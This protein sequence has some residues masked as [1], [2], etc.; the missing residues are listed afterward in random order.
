MKVKEC[1]LNNQNIKEIN[2]L[3]SKTAILKYSGYV[4]SYYGAKGYLVENKKGSSCEIK[5]E[6]L[7][8]NSN[9]PVDVICDFCGK[10]FS[11]EYNKYLSTKDSGNCCYDCRRI[12]SK[13]TNVE[14]YGVED[15]SQL[16][17]VKDKRKETCLDRFGFISNLCSEETKDKIKST[18]RLLYGVD[19]VSQ[20]EMFKEKTKETNLE[21]YGYENPMQNE[22]VKNKVRKSLYENGTCASSKGQNYVHNL[23]GGEKNYFIGYYNVDIFFEKLNIYLEYDGSG[24]KLQVDRGD[25]SEEEYR[26]RELGRYHYLKRQNLK[27]IRFLNYSDNLPSDDVLIDIFNQC[28]NFLI[29]D[30]K[31]FVVV[32][33][34]CLK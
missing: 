24:H 31:Y 9:A 32:D 22:E 26:K 18:N 20:S 15:T 14:R 10:D 11:M 2:M 4:A 6:D 25:I 7:S 21:K 33:L 5:V 17:W 23:L 13:K 34:D 29:N 1:H 19:Y 3:V 27:L 12:K 28:V 30:E 8:P 16:Q